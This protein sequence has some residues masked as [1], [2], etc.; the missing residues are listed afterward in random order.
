MWGQGI[1]SSLISIKGSAPAGVS[2]SGHQYF[3]S[4][5]VPADCPDNTSSCK[6]AN[7]VVHTTGDAG[8]VQFF[9]CHDGSCLTPFSGTWTMT[10]CGGTWTE[11]TAARATT[12]KATVATFVAPN[13]TAQTCDITLTH[14]SLVLFYVGAEL[15]DC[16]AASTTS[17][18]DTSVSNPATGNSATPSITSAGNVTNAGELGL[19]YFSCFSASITNTG[20]YTTG[21]TDGAGSM[22]LF[23]SSL[24]QAGTTTAAV[25]CTIADYLATMIAITP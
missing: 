7:F 5:G 12:A 16:S 13:L 18:V 10:G 21:G 9:T 15:S 3:P 11:V 25:A 2:L 1:R 24:T 8:V 23:K 19:V 4:G 17:P 14:G 22:A 20:T 6:W